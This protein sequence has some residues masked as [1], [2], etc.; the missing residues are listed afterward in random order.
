[1][2]ISLALSGGGFRATVF[3]LGVLG[4]LSCENRMEEVRNISSVSGG[5]LCAGLV[6]SLNNMHWPASPAYLQEIEPAARRLLTSSDLQGALIKRALGNFWSLLGT[7]ADDLSKLIRE[8]W[9]V[10]AR[11]C[12]LPLEPRWMINAT[13]YET[14][15]N[16]R[17]E[18]SRMGDYRFGY[19]NNTD[20]PLADAMA[21]SAGFPVLI[22]PLTLKTGGRDWFEYQE[23]KG[24]V[25]DLAQAAQWEKKPIEPRYAEVHLW[26]GG[27]YDNHGLE[28]FYDYDKSWYQRFGFLIVS[29]AAGQAAETPYQ[30]GFPALLR[31][32][33]GIMMNQVRSLRTRAIIG[34]ITSHPDDQGVFLQM[35]NTWQD[36]VKQPCNTRQA[37]RLG[38][39]CLPVEQARQ[40]ASFATTIRRLSPD[41]YEA[42]YRHGYEVADLTLNAFYQRYFD[43]I[44]YR[45]ACMMS[46]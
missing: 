21:A 7:R 33:T 27:V 2:N 3:H 5:S 37:E 8:Q 39:D 29:D 31:L 32:C 15:K 13:C 19:T 40:L 41:E 46:E 42:L 12:E 35:G 36:I 23:H 34:R 45:A 1:M 18:R 26:D 20:V 10:Q 11:L 28:P 14:G 16:W 38:H 6:F 25:E 22:G 24:D 43:H 17:F 9:G 44:P 4:R 30:K